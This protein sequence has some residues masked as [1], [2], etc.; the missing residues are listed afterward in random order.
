MEEI[1]TYIRCRNCGRYVLQEEAYNHYFC[2]SNCSQ[3]FVRC[4]N[5]GT[6]FLASDSQYPEFCSKE[7]AYSWEHPSKDVPHYHDDEGV[8]I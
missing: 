8:I 3:R 7:C 5:C 1:G 2:S 4:K 6:Y